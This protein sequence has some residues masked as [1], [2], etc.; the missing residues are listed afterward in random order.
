MMKQYLIVLAMCLLGI[1]AYAQQY[2]SLKDSRDGRVYKTVK[3]GNQEWMAENLNAD[4]FRNGDI[5]PQAK[6]D[7]EW[8]AASENGKPAWCYYDNDSKNG[9]KYG[10]LYNWY[11]VSD[12]RGLAPKGW[13]IPSDEEWTVLT[14]YLEEGREY[15]AATKMRSKQDWKYD[16]LGTNSSGFS[17]LPGG[18]R[19]GNGMLYGNELLFYSA[20][21][22]GYWWSSTEDSTNRAWIRTMNTNVS[23]VFRNNWFKANGLSV[24]CLR[25]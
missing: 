15:T 8:K 21:I 6:T 11:A 1:Q 12:A 14:E 9:E 13:H 7:D 4:R 23:T 5:I 24:R 10:K 2:G 25:D 18:M 3:I 17:G 16:V 22:F 20:N 19:F